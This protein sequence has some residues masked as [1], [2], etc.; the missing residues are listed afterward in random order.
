MNVGTTTT[1]AHHHHS[2]DATMKEEL[3]RNKARLFEVL[4]AT[5]NMFVDRHG[6]IPITNQILEKT[7]YIKKKIQDAFDVLM[8]NGTVSEMHE[9]NQMMQNL[10]ERRHPS[11]DH[12]KKNV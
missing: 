10:Y 5:C 4:D 7:R 12:S 2:M 11:F 6:Y 3:C 8:E 1:T 9:L